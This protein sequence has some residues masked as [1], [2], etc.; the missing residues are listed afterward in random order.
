MARTIAISNHK[1]GSGKTTTAVCLSAALAARGYSVLLVDIDAQANASDSLGAPH[2]SVGTY[3]A[4][5]RMEAPEPVHVLAPVGK[6]GALDLLPGSEAL[7]SL[8]TTL[9]AQGDALRL[10]AILKA[11]ADDYDFIVMDTPPALSVL[12]LGALL[13]AD[14]LVIPMEPNALEVRGLSKMAGTVQG[15]APSRARALRSYVLL[16][17]YDNRKG[18]HRMVANAIATSGATLLQ[19]KVRQCVALAEA[20]GAA[21]DIFRYA[22]GSNGAKDYAALAGE[23]LAILG[24]GKNSKR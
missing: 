8:P 6:A 7:D 4:L 9:T 21:K 22:P 15:I 23:Y 2:G 12:T 20:P 17:K 18:L 13:A 14:D 5:S 24:Y 11:Y 19:T 3:E 16:V 10:S 1:G